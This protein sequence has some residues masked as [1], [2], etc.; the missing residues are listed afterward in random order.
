MANYTA[1]EIQ[2]VV[3]GLVRS[4][5]RRPY[6]T[7]GVRRTDITFGDIQEAAAGVFLLYPKSTF[8]LTYLAGQRFR[9]V[10]G[11]FQ[12]SVDNLKNA[13]GVLRQRSLPVRDVSSLVNAKAALLE[14]EGAVTTQ[15]PK[16]VTKIP[17]YVRFNTNIDRFLAAVGDNIKKDGAI[18]QTPEEARMSLG[19]LATDLKTQATEVVRRAKL[20]AGALADYN[21]IELAKVLSQTV[22]VNSRK[23]VSARADQLS[24]MKEP[25]RL[26]VLRETILDL[27]TAK[28]VVRGFGSFAGL[29][30]QIGVTGTL[31]PYADSGRPAI[32]ASIEVSVAGGLSLIPG[33]DV[34]SSTN[35]LDLWVDVISTAGTP[36]Y[37][38]FLPS[39]L[40]PK[41][42]AT[43]AGPFNIG[44][45]SLGNALTGSKLNDTLAVSVNGGANILISITHNIDAN[46][47]RTPAQVAADLTAGLVG[48]GFQGA[49]YFSPLWFDG[50]VLTTGNT[51]SPVHGY[52]QPGSIQAGFEV[53]FYYGPN[54]TTT[55]TVT[56]LI[57]SGGDIVGFIVDGPALVPATTTLDRI[58]YGSAARRVRIEPVNRLAAVNNRS[59]IQIK[60]ANTVAQNTAFTLGFFGEVAGKGQPSTTKVLTDYVTQ[61]SSGVF[62]ASKQNV[63]FTGSVTTSPGTALKVLFTGTPPAVAVD[64]CMIVPSGVNAGKYYIDS[65]TV[66][67]FTVRTPLPFFRDQYNQ[68]VVLENVTIGYDNYVISS[69]NTGLTS[70]LALNGPKE[71]GTVTGVTAITKATTYY[72]RFSNVPTVNPKDYVE[73]YVSSSSTPDFTAVI[74]QVFSDGV[75]LL[76]RA[77]PVGTT[78]AFDDSVLPYARLV[79]AKVSDYDAMAAIINTQLAQSDANLD[80]YF[81]D[82]NRFINPLKYNTNPSDLEIRSTENRVNDL[83]NVLYPISVA[84]TA[85]QPDAVP[86]ADQLVK[87][88]SEK[89]ADRA[90]DLLLSCQFSA[91][92]GLTQEETSYAGAFQ[93]AVRD[94]ATNDL[95]VHKTNRLAATTSPLRSSAASADYETS[96]ED[97]DTSPVVDP[98]VEIDRSIT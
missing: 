10:Y 38:I 98:P 67:G 36:T 40:T 94:V 70:A 20:L 49:T 71:N 50:E 31:A 33:V 9:E 1:E 34:A 78:W 93:K 22:I 26:T 95:P 44:F 72:M 83:V 42:D 89:G 66:D 54:A 88:F 48:T 64:M 75:V 97:L 14:L 28:A 21:S 2:T 5:I 46:T 53:D 80:A 11:N 8:Y 63:L 51:V 91:F 56:N 30:N 39:S 16:D 92:F 25:E 32:P 45:D 43:A 4:S 82:L 76:D 24:G 74:Q 18:V 87:A 55:R 86:Q 52:F 58:R 85:Y 90:L 59:T 57:L 3:E 7:L 84:V 13:L 68:G 65:V 60:F 27:L 17:A 37:Q 69:K 96:T 29:Q 62:G 23:L 12:L 73:F 35:I 41:L 77:L 19:T 79:S 81:T 61:N 6:D 15:P 47:A